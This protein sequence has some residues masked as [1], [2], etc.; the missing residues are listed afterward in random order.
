MEKE[1][2]EVSIARNLCFIMNAV[3]EK[4]NLLD[5]QRVQGKEKQDGTM[6]ESSTAAAIKA[7]TTFNPLAKIVANNTFTRSKPVTERIGILNPKQ[8][9]EAD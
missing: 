4:N 6:N 9:K 8:R 3:I 7:L 5:E 2:N 1:E